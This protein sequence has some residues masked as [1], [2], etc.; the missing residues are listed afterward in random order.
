MRQFCPRPATRVTGVGGPTSTRSTVS[1]TSTTTAS[2]RA[3]NAIRSKIVELMAVVP[4]MTFP[5]EW[6]TI[7]GNRVVYYPWQVLPDPSGGNEVYRFGCV[8]ILEYAGDGQFSYQEDVYNPP[9]RRRSV[10]PLDRGGRPARGRA[11]RAGPLTRDQS[12]HSR[13][14][15]PYTCATFKNQLDGQPAFE[16]GDEGLAR[17]SRRCVPRL[18]RWSSR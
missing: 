11:R 1:G 10:R 12:G 15:H 5:V 3:T 2:S 13:H 18:R 14:G 4:M 17:R 8:T 7:E 6:V 16:R 9:R